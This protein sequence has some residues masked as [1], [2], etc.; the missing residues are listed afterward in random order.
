MRGI[1][2]RFFDW[3]RWSVL[4]KLAVESEQG[5]NSIT[6]PQNYHPDWMLVF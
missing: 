6:Y 2:P 1:V 4:V 5:L 3:R